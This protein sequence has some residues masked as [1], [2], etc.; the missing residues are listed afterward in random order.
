MSQNTRR[1]HIVSAYHF[2]PQKMIL[3]M[4]WVVCIGVHAQETSQTQVVTG[5]DYK[6]VSRLVEKSASLN[7]QPLYTLAYRFDFQNRDKIFVQ[8]FGNIDASGEL[9]YLS[10]SKIV[11]FWSRD[12]KEKLATVELQETAASRSGEAE[13]MPALKEFL[14]VKRK[15]PWPQNL[16]AQVNI[17]KVVYQNYPTGARAWIENDTQY[18]ETLF[19]PLGSLPKRVLGQI[20]LLITFPTAP[21]SN[22]YDIDVQAAIQERRRLEDWRS[23]NISPETSSSAE[24]FLGLFVADLERASGSQ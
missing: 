18:F 23:D 4:L 24:T 15:S 13:E 14:P 5:P 6:I 21:N 17:L 2:V 20:A 1:K 8:D 22:P 10:P 11:E 9:T 19:K 3:L 12:R 16:P 7:G